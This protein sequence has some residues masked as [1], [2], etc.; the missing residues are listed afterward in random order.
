MANAFKPDGST[1][2]F[3]PVFRFN[4]GKNYLFQIYSR[5]G[6]LLFETNNPNQGWDGRYNGEFVEMGVYVYRLVYE[7]PDESTSVQTGTVTVVY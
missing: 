5:W 4:N 3:K 6:N 1:S 2:D 7:N